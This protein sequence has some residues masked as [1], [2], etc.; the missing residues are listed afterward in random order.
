MPAQAVGAHLE[1]VGFGVGG[2]EMENGVRILQD[3]GAVLAGLGLDLAFARRCG[4]RRGIFVRAA[5]TLG[6]HRASRRDAGA[7]QV[8]R[9]GLGLEVVEDRQGF[10]A[11]FLVMIL[12]DGGHKIAGGGDLGVACVQLRGDGLG[13]AGVNS[14]IPGGGILDLHKRS[15]P[16]HPIAS[17]RV[18]INDVGA[19]DGCPRGVPRLEHRSGHAPGPSD[20]G[21]SGEVAQLAAVEESALVRG[22]D[23]SHGAAHQGNAVAVV[24]GD[25]DG[26]VLVPLRLRLRG[27]ELEM[28]VAHVARDL[29]AGIALP[30]FEI[31]D[32]G[33][34]WDDSLRRRLPGF[35]R[36]ATVGEGIR[37]QLHTFTL[38]GGLQ[39]GLDRIGPGPARH[40]PRQDVI[41]AFDGPGRRDVRRGRPEPDGVGRVGMDED[42]VEE[43]DARSAVLRGGQR[44]APGMEKGVPGK[45][46]ARGGTRGGDVEVV[47]VDDS[48]GTIV[49][50]EG[51]R[52]EGDQDEGK[53]DRGKGEGEGDPHGACLRRV[54]QKDNSPRVEVTP[55]RA[56]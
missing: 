39:L 16:G 44:G 51:P 14:I 4:R 35:L 48:P 40:R 10:D 41:G 12:V 22:F 50:G 53:E 15:A 7:V 49:A 32:S 29:S 3:D 55:G 56:T 28:I 33:V 37:P 46:I 42:P 8:D 11:P 26:H 20:D 21:L 18:F 1:V 38:A 19:Q 30:L 52:R 54:C 6:E 25:N 2:I 13:I 47:D 27:V 17:H 43:A 45:L 36:L 34:D 31:L 5:E 9:A 24:Q 23:Q